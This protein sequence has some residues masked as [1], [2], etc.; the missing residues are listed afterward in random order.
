MREVPGGG[1]TRGEGWRAGLVGDVAAL[2]GRECAAN[3]VLGTELQ[4][5]VVREQGVL[6]PPRSRA[7]PPVRGRRGGD[8]TL[9]RCALDA[10]ALG[11]TEGVARLR[12]GC[13]EAESPKTLNPAN[14]QRLE[15]IA[16]ERLRSEA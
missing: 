9:G 12:A 3:Q 8:A 11:L 15:Q 10:T 13:V 4:A 14:W 7:E 5:R 1:L 2:R 16:G 6:H